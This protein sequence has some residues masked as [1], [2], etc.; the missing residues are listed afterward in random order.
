MLPYAVYVTDQNASERPP[1]QHQLFPLFQAAGRG[2][3]GAHVCM[4]S[5]VLRSV[6]KSSDNITRTLMFVI[7]SVKTEMTIAYFISSSPAGDFFCTEISEKAY[8]VKN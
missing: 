8:V 2:N 1:G 3:T 4:T 6:H 7:D 5:Y